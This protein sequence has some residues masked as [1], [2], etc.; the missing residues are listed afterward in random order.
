MYF[1]DFTKNG[2]VGFD[3][4]L[5]EMAHANL[6]ATGLI[7]GIDPF[8]GKPCK[9]VLSGDSFRE[10]L[11]SSTTQSNERQRNMAKGLSKYL[12]GVPEKTLAEC[13]DWINEKELRVYTAEA[14][15]SIFSFLQKNIRKSL[16]YF[17][18]YFG[19]H[20][21]SGDVVGGIVHQDLQRLSYSDGFFDVVMTSEVMEHVPDAL[22]AERE[23]VRVLKPG[24]GYIFTVPYMANSD[25]DVVRAVI[26][27]G[28]VKH[29]LAPQYHGDPIR[30]KDGILVY[31]I[32]SER[33]LRERFKDLGADFHTY[34]IYDES[35]GIISYD[36]F[37]HVVV[38]KDV[39]D[40]GTDTPTAFRHND[41]KERAIQLNA[42][43]S[44]KKPDIGKSGFYQSFIFV[45]VP[46][47]G[48][49]SF[50][51][52]IYQT[53]L[54]NQI[55]KEKIHIPGFGGLSNDK[56][57]SQLT[58]N[59]LA[60][61]RASNKLVLGVHCKFGVHENHKLNMLN[62]FYYILLRDPVKRFVSHY[63]FFNWHLGYSNLKG[64]HLNDLDEEVLNSLLTKMS[65]IQLSHLINGPHFIKSKLSGI[66]KILYRKFTSKPV[67][68][69]ADDAWLE[70]AERMLEAEYG[71][72]GILEKM[73]LSLK[74][75]KMCS[76]P[77]LQFSISDYPIINEG[78]KMVGDIPINDRI[79]ESIK[80]FNR[81]DFLLYD[82]ASK[83]LDKKV[84]ALCGEPS[85][86]QV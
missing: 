79:I 58:K 70:E 67:G 68:H 73:D 28:Q 52:Y 80:V 51:K 35:A 2:D 57:V 54:A 19:P 82:M 75:L 8:N 16:L 33:E 72:F 61:F 85:S 84:D 65:N 37:V 34:N 32:F 6:H 31:R 56:N 21:C 36:A 17:S 24:G 83:L 55:D 38:I 5:R 7:K 43:A 3:N 18:E 20:H 22:S 12:F 69:L 41:Q 14:N 1:N 9:Y 76:P 23:I 53:A 64:I 10:G 15:S 74:Y 81:Y 27:N 25:Y 29:L 63:N 71:A 45:H 77:W 60:A 78:Q 59:E 49:T 47:C 13:C 50:R 62:P 26:E 46:K 66:R 30:P 48:G 44:I 42:P 11:K 4:N 86:V 39:N 40:G